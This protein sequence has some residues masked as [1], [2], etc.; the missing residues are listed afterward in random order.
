MNKENSENKLKIFSLLNEIIE[1]INNDFSNSKIIIFGDLNY[2]F[3]ASN[4]N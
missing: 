2:N 3:K 4:G 1:R